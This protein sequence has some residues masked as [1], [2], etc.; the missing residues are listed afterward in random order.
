MATRLMHAMGRST[1]IV[2]ATLA[3]AVGIYWA[4]IARSAAEGAAMYIAEDAGMRSSMLV[5]ELQQAAFAAGVEAIV[6][7]TGSILLFVRKSL[8]RA[9][10]IGSSVAG[11]IHLAVIAIDSEHPLP[12]V[13]ALPSLIVLLLASTK[14]T[15]GWIVHREPSGVPREGIQQAV[16]GAR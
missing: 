2:A 3:L 15:A 10:V 14:S 4:L 11:I 5:R 12:L 16:D 13:M 7:S 1:G 8:G 9:L 6:S